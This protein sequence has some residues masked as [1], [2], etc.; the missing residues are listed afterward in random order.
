MKFI[1][2]LP[3]AVLCVPGGTAGPA[4][5]LQK[6]SHV[7]GTAKAKINP[8]LDPVSDAKFMKADYPDDHR[9]H[10][11]HKFDYPYPTV[12]DHEDYDK[13]Y[14]QDKNDDN[15]YSAAQLEYDGMKNRVEKE[16]REMEH[17]YKKEQ[18]DWKELQSVKAAEK[19]AE[20]AAKEA[21]RKE[22][23]ADKLHD[24]ATQNLTDAKQ[25]VDKGQDTTGNEI[26]DLEEC[27]KQ[28]A[29]A[30]RKLKALLEESKSAGADL[31]AKAAAED[32]AEGKEMSAEEKEASLEKKVAEETKEHELAMSSVQKETQDVKNAEDA[33]EKA[34]A[35]LRQFRK[36]SVDPDGGVYHKNKNG[37][38]RTALVPLSPLLAGVVAALCAQ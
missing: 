38:H 3:L 20:D 35:R 25:N 37:A 29:E 31:D 11:Y 7:A 21:E 2:A 22:K 12:Q 33:L 27:K 10:V 13:D 4:S 19:L 16:K 14:V 34:A 26:N 15:G 30:K 6:R 5:H 36:D 17:A 9:S 8:A 23:L 32:A 1:V 28:L 18:E 24:E